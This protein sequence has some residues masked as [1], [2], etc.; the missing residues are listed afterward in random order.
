MPQ[1]TKEY[2]KKHLEKQKAKY[3]LAIDVRELL[4]RHEVVYHDKGDYLLMSCLFPDHDDSRPSFS[5]HT[6]NFGYNC[7]GCG[8]KG[9]LV[10]LI[11]AL[12]WTIGDHVPVLVNV[13]STSEWKEH[14][15]NIQ[16][17]LVEREVPQHFPVPNGFKILRP[18][19]PK[20]SKHWDYVVSRGIDQLMDEFKIGYTSQRDYAEGDDGKPVYGSM[21][22]SRII[23]PVHDY[24]G[25]VEWFEGRSIF[26]KS[27]AKYWRPRGARRHNNLFNY[28][29]VMKAGFTYAIITEGILDAM[30]LWHWGLPGVCVYGTDVTE[31]Q[32]DLLSSFDRLYMCFDNDNAG[33][34][35]V[36]KLKHRVSFSG[37]SIYRILLPSGKDPAEMSEKLFVSRMKRASKVY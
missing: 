20:C 8:K 11:K 2:A 24:T 31:G 35:A 30:F 1:L 14:M 12:G 23:I 6:G 29:R 17:S 16:M 18:D 10:D 21:Y 13:A 15:K 28:F 26:S 36:R 3:S 7:W 22:K 9:K 37:I 4:E 32:V 34:E 27:D 5:I 25:K 19:D 33:N